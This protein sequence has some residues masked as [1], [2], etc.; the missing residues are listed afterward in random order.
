MKKLFISCPMR[1]RTDENIRKSIEWLHKYAELVT[2]EELEVIES[3]KPFEVVNSKNTSVYMLGES[4]KR[5]AEADY[6]V[7]VGYTDFWR[8]CSHERNIALAYGLKYIQ[9]NMEYAP[10]FADAINLERNHW[11]NTTASCE[12]VGKS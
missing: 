3:Y 1:G 4:I 5:M 11:N 12:A 10:C 8:G 7:G 2:G 6:V 9:A